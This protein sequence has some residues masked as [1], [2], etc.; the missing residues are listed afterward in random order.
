MIS[1]TLE[2]VLEQPTRCP[3]DLAGH[4]V[5]V[6]LDNMSDACWKWFPWLESSM[7]RRLICTRGFGSR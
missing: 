3:E 4:A 2:V 5:E 6:V 7:S 1:Q